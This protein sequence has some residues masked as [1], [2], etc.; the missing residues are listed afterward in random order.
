MKNPQ[1]ILTAF[2]G[3]FLLLSLSMCKK[4]QAVMEGITEITIGTGRDATSPGNYSPYGMWEPAV[5]IY[6]TLVNLDQECNPIPCLAE[7]WEV[8]EDSLE[9]SFHLR[10]DIFFHDG[11]SF[12]APAVKENVDKLKTGNWMIVSR[13]I[14]DVKIIDDFTVQFCLHRSH[15][16]FLMALSAVQCSII[17]PSVIQPEP[18]SEKKES[19]SMSSSKMGGSKDSSKMP[20]SKTMGS[21]D[22]SKMGTGKTDGKSAMNGM[23]G[24]TGKKYVIAR[25]VG[26]GPY[27]W[28]EE[29]YVRNRSFSVVWNESYWQGTPRFERINWDVIPDAGARAIALESG[30]I[31]LTGETP[32]STLTNEN[33]TALKN[34]DNVRIVSANNWGARMVII[35]HTRPPFTNKE[36]RK[37]L[38]YAIDLE[39]IQKLLGELAEV[40]PGPLGPD[41]PFTDP[42]LKLYEYDPDKANRILDKNNLFDTDNDG[43]RE[44]NG[45]NI[46][47]EIITSKH[48]ALAV[49]LQESFKGIGID[50]KI[51]QK[52]S[53]S[54]FQLLDQMQFDIA[55][56]HN[57]PSFSLNLYNQFS[58]KGRWT[59]HFNDPELEK[60]LAEYNMCS[61]FER[62]K[63]LSIRIQ[64]MVH[65]KEI[66]LLAINEKKTAAYNKKLGSFVFP[67]EEWVGADQE[68]WRMK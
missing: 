2:L 49:L 65:E 53:A 35:N 9:Y 57:I 42:S 29:K 58:D 67:P 43:I 55:S 3:L 12:N 45:K 18:E 8:T 19:A 30:K 38:K 39:G 27:K 7:S 33:I 25:P 5:I 50:L 22:S 31:D 6:E 17:A 36:V 41:T 54:T 15:P 28:D 4:E 1:K 13:Y 46:S 44:Y 66:I 52:E 26:T 10:K 61:D 11:T 68:I 14:K 16:T 23:M 47:I 24:A 51:A 62:Y 63:E 56:H 37:A 21:M 64:Q 59:M 60:V 32:N 48:P 34:V 40:C 20:P